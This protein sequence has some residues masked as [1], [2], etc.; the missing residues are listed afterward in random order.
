M[1]TPFNPTSG[2]IV[3]W[4]ELEG[5]NGSVPVAL[6]VDTGA[7]NTLI[8]YPHLFAA[9]YSSAPVQGRVRLDMGGGSAAVSTLPVLSLRALGQKRVNFVVGAYTLPPGANADGLI[10]LDFFRGYELKI[11]FRNGQITLT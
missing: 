2:S 8:G 11:D 7:T 3:V 4:G 5:P 6:L 9:G 10:G 1:S